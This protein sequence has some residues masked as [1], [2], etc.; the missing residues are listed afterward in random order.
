MDYIDYAVMSYVCSECGKVYRVKKID[1]VFKDPND[2]RK[3]IL[4]RD[5]YLK[6]HGYCPQCHREIMAK[7]SLIRS[8]SIDIHV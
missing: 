3:K 5:G 8:K 7:L 4:E 6:S 2:P 1:A